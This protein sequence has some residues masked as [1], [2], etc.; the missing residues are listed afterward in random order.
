MFDH[1]TIRVKDFGKAVRF[2][3][4]A[5]APLGFKVLHES[6]GGIGLGDGKE[7][8]IWISHDTP[9]TTGL[10]LAFTS[11]DHRRVDAFYAAALAAGG[12]DNGGPGPRPDYGPNYY[13]AFA[14]DPDGNNIE[15]VFNK[16]K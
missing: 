3:K 4:E 9:V 8:T 12:R 15:A 2:Y 14:H 11:P 10:H 5:L 13:A 7:P 1:V 6:S 16:A